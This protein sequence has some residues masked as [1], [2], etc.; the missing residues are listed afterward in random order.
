[1][2][3]WNLLVASLICLMKQNSLLGCLLSLSS[4]AFVTVDHNILLKKLQLN[5]IQGNNV[6][7]I[8]G[9]LANRLQYI[10]LTKQFHEIFRC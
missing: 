2:H 6:K 3:H 5:G 9:N 7:W 1:M 4:N 8:E 10:E